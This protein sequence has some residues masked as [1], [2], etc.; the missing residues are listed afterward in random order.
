MAPQLNNNSPPPNDKDYVSSEDEDFNPEEAEAVEEEG[1][2]V[3]ELDGDAMD[4]E[5]PKRRQ[6]KKRKQREVA[7]DL[8]FENS[9][10]EA[11]IQKGARKKRR[12]EQHGGEDSGGEGGFVKTRSMR[13]AMT[14]EQ[15]KKPISSLAES[16][17]DIDA[18][19]K[20]MN[21]MSQSEGPV[22][23][24]L[25]GSKSEMDARAIQEASSLHD[26]DHDMVEIQE[27]YRFAGRTEKTTKKVPRTSVEAR[28]YFESRQAQAAAD[29]GTSLAASPKTKLSPY[30][31]QPL[32]RPLRRI[33]TYDPNPAGIIKGLPA[34]GEALTESASKGNKWNVV[35][36]S[37]LKWHMDAKAPKMNVVDKSK[38]DWTQHV[39]SMGD[40]EELDA[41]GRAKGSYLERT[42][43]L[44]RVGA[45][46][47]DTMSR[48]K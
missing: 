38:L 45:R 21:S 39:T 26:G 15:S 20:E 37:K 32:L 43:F 47:D 13:A 18:L 30:T 24:P 25:P 48:K 23:Q 40:R 29:S 42:D 34:A 46:I 35:D 19:W 33:S 16:T 27:T 44:G 6:G 41:A 7:E 12:K 31:G 2:S 14:E 22:Y 3:D 5:L 28:K 17:V 8:G 1:S 10:D 9:G 4:A 11:T 36:K